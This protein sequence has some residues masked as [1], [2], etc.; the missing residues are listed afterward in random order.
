MPKS[1]DTAPK[2]TSYFNFLCFYEDGTGQQ[3]NYVLETTMPYFLIEVKD[4]PVWRT[5][6]HLC[7]TYN[8]IYNFLN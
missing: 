8:N 5:V 3:Q 1:T 2:G 6:Y 7:S 4:F